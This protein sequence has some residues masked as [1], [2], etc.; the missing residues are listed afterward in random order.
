MKEETKSKLEVMKKRADRRRI[1]CVG[2]GRAQDGSEQ[3]EERTT[4]KTSHC[5]RECL[6]VVL[7][8]TALITSPR[9]C[10]CP[11]CSF[12]CL[13][14]IASFSLHVIILTPTPV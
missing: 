12:V 5:S 8:T 13:A 3:G 6:R 9:P 2:M 14:E 4:L 1:A 10:P 7:L 11:L